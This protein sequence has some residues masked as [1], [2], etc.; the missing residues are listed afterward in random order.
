MFDWF[1]LPALVTG[2]DNLEDIAGEVHEILAF[3]LIG[4]AAVHG[5]AAI[6]H[7]IIDRDTTL[8]RMLGPVHTN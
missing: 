7:H 2:V 8:L 6:K 3:T 1:T 4:L 5:L